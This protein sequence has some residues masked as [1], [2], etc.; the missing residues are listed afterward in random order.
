[1]CGGGSGSGIYSELNIF[2]TKKEMLH[3]G[4]LYFFSSLP[5]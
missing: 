2:Y 3:D 4:L 1:M 5:A